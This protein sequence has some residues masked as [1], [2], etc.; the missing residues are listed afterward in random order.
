MQIIETNQ[1]LEEESLEYQEQ[2]KQRKL[3]EA[4]KTLKNREKRLKRK[5]HLLLTGF[6][7]A[8]VFI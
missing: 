7:S 4:A 6:H 5:N 8:C 3:D 2:L 1:R